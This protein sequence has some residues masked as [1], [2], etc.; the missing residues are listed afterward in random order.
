MR[1]VNTR[2]AIHFTERKPLKIT[3]TIITIIKREV[4]TD[5]GSTDLLLWSKKRI[6]EE[7][8]DDIIKG[9]S[10]VR[11]KKGTVSK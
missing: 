1:A 5:S 10:Q 2:S 7:G 4:Y 3:S 11:V 6:R 9:V 8:I